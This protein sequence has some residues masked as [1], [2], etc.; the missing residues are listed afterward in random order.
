MLS[1]AL[2]GTDDL[3]VDLLE[4]WNAQLGENPSCPE[5]R[6]TK[7][8]TNKKKTEYQWSEEQVV[9]SETFCE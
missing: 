4:V 1:I 5:N 7:P 3:N 8:I 2:L 6:T 9:T